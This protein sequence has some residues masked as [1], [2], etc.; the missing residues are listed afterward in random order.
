[1]LQQLDGT[2]CTNT[3]YVFDDITPCRAPEAIISS[4]TQLPE[5]KQPRALLT[6]AVDA[7]THKHGPLSFGH[8]FAHCRTFRNPYIISFFSSCFG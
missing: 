7:V 6:M 2:T 3:G 8:V 4:A 1:M 5:H